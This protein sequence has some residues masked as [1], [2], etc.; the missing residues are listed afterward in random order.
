[1]IVNF[2]NAR[3]LSLKRK[4]KER[5]KLSIVILI[6]VRLSYLSAPAHKSGWP[7]HVEDAGSGTFVQNPVVYI[8]T[9][10]SGP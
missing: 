3:S 4:K 2:H 10:L 8:V 7:V 1:M 9:K 6:M 5:K